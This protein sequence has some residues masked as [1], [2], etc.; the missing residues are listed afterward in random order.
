MQIKTSKATIRKIEQEAASIKRIL[1]SINHNLKPLAGQYVMLAFPEDPAA[2]RAFSIVSCH[3]QQIELC[4]K[5]HGPFTKKL[6]EA[7]LGQELLVFGPYGTFTLPKVSQPTIFIAG[8]IGITPLYNLANALVECNQSQKKK[9]IL[10]RREE[11][12]EQKENEEHNDQ[13]S[14]LFYSVK[15]H[16]EIALKKELTH[17]STKMQVT[18]LCTCEGSP[19]ISADYLQQ[20]VNNLSGYLYY[21]CGP[22]LMMQVITQDLISN[23]VSQD[24]IRQENF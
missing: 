15:T 14:Y 6:F 4:I 23:G 13:K 3:D 19:R 2:K 24:Q 11:G 17:L 5:E 8:G 18:Y 22:P 10:K 20:H 21:I 16:D 7:K 12:N 9:K 1:L